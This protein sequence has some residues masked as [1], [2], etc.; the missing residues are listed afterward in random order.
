MTKPKL[1]EAPSKQDTERFWSSVDK[2]DDCWN[3]KAGLNQGYGVFLTPTIGRKWGAH[4]FAYETVVGPL[5]DGLVID[6]RCHSDAVARGEC[7]GG[8]D[9]PHR[10]CVNP[11]HLEPVTVRE[12]TMR[13]AGPTS[14]NAK[15]THCP[16]GHEF[17]LEN[18]GY[19]PSG[20]RKCRRCAVRADARYR[21][22][23]TSKR[24][25]CPICEKTFAWQ[26]KQKHL[27]RHAIARTPPEE[28]P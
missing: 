1:F 2:T 25:T 13:G 10:R 8:D 27:V 28:A 19:E 4:R 12:N 5:P 17:T 6:H 24:W 9:C 3:W 16:R 23:N 20:G 14:I 18:T 21:A 26:T 11:D 22:R 7:T 15:K